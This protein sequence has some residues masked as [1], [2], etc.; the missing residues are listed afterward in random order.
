[1]YISGTIISRRT[2]PVRI[3]PTGAA[4]AQPAAQTS[5]AGR[6]T[7]RQG[8]GHGGRQGQRERDAHRYSGRG[9]FSLSL[10][11]NIYKT[12]W[13]ESEKEDRETGR[14]KRERH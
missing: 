3:R 5:T 7:G 11:P 14:K 4:T 8:G 6:Q 1:M 9:K 13:K 2:A 12:G 10:F